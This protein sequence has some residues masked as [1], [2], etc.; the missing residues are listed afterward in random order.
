MSATS[1][2]FDLYAQ[3]PDGALYP[4]VRV[5]RP[6]APSFDDLPFRTAAIGDKTINYKLLGTP[7]TGNIQAASGF[8]KGIDTLA[9][10]SSVG[11]LGFGVM[12]LGFALYMRLRLSGYR[13]QPLFSKAMR[14]WAGGVAATGLVI[15][16][17]CLAVLYKRHLN[18]EAIRAQLT[19]DQG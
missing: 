1:N 17:P 3:G 11:W 4:V 6:R 8:G 10:L 18:A 5:D 7:P 14:L 19:R 13:G 2:T 15:M 12:P 16:P 9:N